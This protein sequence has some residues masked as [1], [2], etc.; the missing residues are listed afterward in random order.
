MR[1]PNRILVA[2][3]NPR[4]RASSPAVKKAAQIARA[5]G[6]EL[7]LF[8]AVTAP[9]FVDMLVFQN[10]S[11]AAFDK[12]QRVDALRRLEVIAERL[13][14]EGTR[15]STAVTIDFPAYEAIIRQASSARSDLIVVEAHEGHKV[16]WLL[17]LTDWE[18]LRHSALPVLLVKNSRPY[19][20]PVVLAAVDPTHAFAKSSRLDEDILSAAT[21]LGKALRGTL[22]AIHA[23]PPLPIGIR[24][25]EFKSR[26]ITA[27]LSEL[28]EAA[29]RK[30]FDAALKTASIPPVRRHLVGQHPVDAI[31]QVARTTRGS[32]VVMGAISRSGLKRLFIGNTAEQVLDQLQCDVLVVK[33]KGF[34]TGV[35]QARRGPQL[36]A[37][38][39]LTT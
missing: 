32:I 19:R 16:P 10:K 5:C 24:P 21:V 28:A 35:R 36:L 39:A 3:K 20:H 29:A 22:H 15:V 25:A 9:V 14:S 18:L 11:L 33:H 30:G 37:M 13:R 2:V 1:T 31:P 8:H 26:G 23:F 12:D 6:A 38:P 34:K 27:D 4:S 7:Q 17:R